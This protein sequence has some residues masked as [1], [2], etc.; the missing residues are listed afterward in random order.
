MPAEHRQPWARAG[1]L[2]GKEQLAPDRGINGD[3][4]NA[5]REG[6]PRNGVLTAIEDFQEAAG[7]ELELTV[8]PELHGQNVVVALRDGTPEQFVLRDHDTLRIYP[9]WMISEGI[10]DPG[11]RIAP[12]A[13]QSLR[14]CDPA[15]LLGDLPTL[16]FQVNLHG[17]ADA[18]GEHFGI[19]EHVWWAQLREV[20]V[21]TLNQ[22]PLPSPVIEVVERALLR[23]SI[24]PS[25]AL[26]V[27]ASSSNRRSPSLTSAPS[28]AWIFM[29]WLSM[30][31]RSWIEAI[32]CTVPTASMMMGIALGATVVTTTGTGP[33][34]GDAAI[35]RIQT[36]TAETF[37]L[38]PD[39]LVGPGRAPQL[40][41]ARH[42][43]MYLARRHTD[44]TLPAI[45]AR[46]GG[47]NHT[48]VLHACR[49]T[50]Q[51]LAGDPE[52]SELVHA[53]QQRLTAQGLRAGTDRS[54]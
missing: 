13:R 8:L 24:W 15:E 54:E 31:E 37:G 38:S 28:S 12:G 46:F 4:A 53:L 27:R 47:R 33:E 48:T 22:L 49:R 9:D 41:W 40:A 21:E 43:A 44:A 45:G 1:I 18:L 50:T 14:L 5:E 52:A 36:L 7:E 23:A 16:G 26:R 3:L 30:R 20:V 34:A 35:E 42:V 6:G 51:R 11:Y 17:I 39:E 29:I 19:A 32:A 10:T 2:P 25:C